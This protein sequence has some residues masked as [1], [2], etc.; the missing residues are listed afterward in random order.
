MAD[1]RRTTLMG[2]NPVHLVGRELKV[3]DTAPDFL[4]A[5]TGLNK[6]SLHDYAGKIR[7]VSVVPSLD[8]GVCDLQTK[9]FNKEAA[10]F[11][12]DVVILTV[13]MDLPFAQARWCGAAGV[14][15]VVTL[16][17]YYDANFGTAYGVLIDELRLLNRSIFIID[18]EGI[19]RYV[20]MVGENHDHPDYDAALAALAKVRG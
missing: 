17:D 11:N 4:L 5:D 14:D 1:A 20:E 6:K 12:D 8:T 15:R 2:G 18:A 3:G 13:S 19:V 9:R 10:G 16:S 7:L